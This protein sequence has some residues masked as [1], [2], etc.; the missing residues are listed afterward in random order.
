MQL[1]A[2]ICNHMLN[3]KISFRILILVAF[4]AA[5]SGC[6]AIDKNVF[7]DNRDFELYPKVSE[8]ANTVLSLDSNIEKTTF[9]V[10]SKKIATARRLK[11]LINNK[12]SYTIA[13][14]PE[15][16]ISKEE[17]LQPPYMNNPR[18]SFTFMI[19]ERITTEK[20]YQLIDVQINGI[21]DGV[22]TNKQNDYKKA[23]LYAKREAIERA[24]V[25]VKSKTTLKNL[26]LEKDVI[27]SQSEAILIAGYQVID[28]GYGQDHLIM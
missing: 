23:V 12:R 9:Y 11:I 17:F 27:E 1:I 4:I 26:V 18:L 15:G 6:V 10:D 24:G 21:S 28:I 2:R 16:Y 3:G 7:S 8:D 20:D 13:A 5:A 22:R 19:G 25:Q 14:S